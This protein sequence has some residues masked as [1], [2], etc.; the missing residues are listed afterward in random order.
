MKKIIYS[1]FAVLFLIVGCKKDEPID[2]SEDNV[3]VGGIYLS[4]TDLVE[5]NYTT[6]IQ[7]ND[8][9]YSFN[10]IGGYYS[11]YSPTYNQNVFVI[12]F[13]DSTKNNFNDLE[14]RF[15]MSPIKPESF[16]KPNSFS[17]DTII[18]SNDIVV[19]YTSISENFYNVDSIE[20]NWESASFSDFLFEG[21]GS[22]QIPEIKSKLIPDTYYPKQTVVFE[23]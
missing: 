15:F 19:P 16:F 22:F 14:F 18:I 20:F 9:T 6:T 13:I 7:I 5:T 21:K 1:F 4:Y 11:S 23:F 2:N 12:V 10:K 3:I 17:V 8:S